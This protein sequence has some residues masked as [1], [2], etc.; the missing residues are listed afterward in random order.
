MDFDLK[1]V[2][3]TFSFHSR[4]RIQGGNIFY[5]KSA[6]FQKLQ[7]LAKSTFLSEPSRGQHQMKGHLPKKIIPP[8][9]M[10]L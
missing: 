9:I 6:D 1:L 7:I 10:S 4:V 8:Y 5:S 2:K 3:L